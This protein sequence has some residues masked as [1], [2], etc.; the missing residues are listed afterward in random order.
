MI[1]LA[2]HNLGYSS[3]MDRQEE[4]DLKKRN[5]FNQREDVH[6]VQFKRNKL[7]HKPLPKQLETF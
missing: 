1:F 4:R 7:L 3:Q 6:Y 5:N 2:F